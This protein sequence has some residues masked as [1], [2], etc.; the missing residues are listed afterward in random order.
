MPYYAPEL[1][2]REKAIRAADT[3][4]QKRNRP[5]IAFTAGRFNVPRGTLA[6]RFDG[7][8]SRYEPRPELKRL[9]EENDLQITVYRTVKKLLGP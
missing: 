3:C 6:R 8:N 7:Q 1:P 9:T 5:N 4:L 2:D